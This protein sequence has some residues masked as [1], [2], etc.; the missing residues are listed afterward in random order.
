M[1]MLMFTAIVLPFGVAL[2]SIA[3]AIAIFVV[4]VVVCSSTTRFALMFTV[5]LAS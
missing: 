3:I 1:S 5:V 4:I 2:I